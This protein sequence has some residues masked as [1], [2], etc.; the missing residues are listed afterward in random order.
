MCLGIWV[1]RVFLQI[2]LT[3]SLGNW[4]LITSSMKGWKPF[5]LVLIVW[6]INES[7][8][9]LKSWCS[10]P[11]LPCPVLHC[12]E[13]SGVS[14]QDD[15]PVGVPDINCSYWFEF[16]GGTFWDSTVF[17]EC[18]WSPWVVLLSLWAIWSYSTSN[19]TLCCSLRDVKSRSIFSRIWPKASLSR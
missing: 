9:A 13:L 4:A 17:P 1:P 19:S 12:V 6:L 8:S 10:C 11:R 2:G 3:P 7:A 14:L 5:R 18:C 15:F 16:S